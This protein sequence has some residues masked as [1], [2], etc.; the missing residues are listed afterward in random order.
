LG[1]SSIRELKEIL[2]STREK[3]MNMI[4]KYDESLIPKLSNLHKLVAVFLL[5]I[6]M[7]MLLAACGGGGVTS[8]SVSSSVSS[9]TGSLIDGY[10]T[11]GTVCLDTN[12]NGQCDAGEPSATTGASGVF[13]LSIP[14]GTVTTGKNIAAY[15]PT[16]ASDTDGPITAPYTLLAP[17]PT[18]TTST[19]VTPLTTLIALNPASGVAGVAAALGISEA[20]VTSDYIATPNKSAHN[21]AQYLAAVIATVQSTQSTATPVSASISSAVDSIVGNTTFTTVAAAAS[22]AALTTLID[23]AKAVPGAPSIGTAT[24]GSASATVA[25]TA[26]S[27]AGGTP[28][29]G[30]TVTSSPGSLTATG[31]ASPITVTGLTNGTAYTFTVHASNAGGNSIE[32]AA[33]N[34]VTPAASSGSTGTSS[35]LISFDAAGVT[36]TLTDFGGDIGTIVTD[37]AGGTNLVAMIV[38][39]S[40]GSASQTWAG[41]T[42]STGASQSVATIPLTS[43]AMTMT[44]RVWSPSTGLPI[45]LKLEDAANNTHTVETEA[46]STVAN[47]WETLTFNFANQ[48]TGTAAFDSTFTYNKV[49]IFPNFNTVQSGGASATY[50]FDDL[51]FVASASAT[52]PGAPTIGTAIGGNASATVSFTAPSSTGGSVISGYTVTSSPAGGTD[53]NAGTTGLTHTITGLTNGTS[54]TF[55][56]KATNSVGTSAASTASNAVTP[57]VSSGGGTVSTASSWALGGTSDFNGAT[58]SLV[59]SQPAGGLQSNAAMVVVANAAQYFGTTFLTIPNAEFCTTAQPTITLEIYA[60]ASGKN[61]DLKLEQDGNSALNIEMNKTSVAGWHTYTFNCITDSGSATTPPTAPYVEGT[62]YNKMSVLFNFL[63]VSTGE[64]WYF[65][66]LTY[67]PTAATTYV[68]PPPFSAPTTAA[69]A[70][71]HTVLFSVLTTSAADIAGTNFRPDWGQPTVYTPLTI[72]GV[73]TV[74]YSG[75][76]YEG[77][78]LA[79]PTD[80]SAAT[81]VHFDVWS[82][83]TLLNFALISTTTVGE[84]HVVKTLTTGWNSIDIPLTSFIGGSFLHPVSLTAVDQ[85][86]FTDND[87]TTGGTVYIQNLYF[88]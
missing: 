49:S 29:S 80:V 53:S 54:Y 43:G 51:T 66:Q 63:S 39:G 50:Y 78:Q 65:D 15:V 33:S 62:V 32:S 42:V 81:Y 22:P 30:Y 74:E 48:A 71:S 25:F 38:K 2:Q 12:S 75:L 19:V 76:T 70:P 24:G 82:N 83:V 73:E 56:V 3:K 68:A 17:A 58:S 11:G 20:T 55:T 36:Y 21:I 61:I 85:L 40:S 1:N 79:S 16:S 34:S 47:A 69:A 72:G 35:A 41:T 86:S 37:P 60:P 28:I 52:A 18:S 26:P 44:M 45:R 10:I 8:P 7:T 67:T 23:T 13:S 77:I 14:S 57:A 6:A 27:S 4:N 84:V 9:I 31:T 88:Y 5:G 46:T 87:A 59:T 64:T